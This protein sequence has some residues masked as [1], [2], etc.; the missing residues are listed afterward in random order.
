LCPVHEGGHAQAIS[1]LQNI[2]FVW[3][4]ATARFSQISDKSQ[5]GCEKGPRKA[6]ACALCGK[7]LCLILHDV[8][9]DVSQ[10]VAQIESLPVAGS[11][12]V[13]HDDRNSTVDIRLKGACVKCCV[14]RKYAD[15]DA[16]VF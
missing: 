3:A 8:K 5:A 4:E 6:M 2:K 1:L 9:H 7:P 10:F 11:A 14:G 13:S 16:L 12:L 15:A